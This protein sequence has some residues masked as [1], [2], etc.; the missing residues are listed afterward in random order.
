MYAHLSLAYDCILVH[1]ITPILNHVLLYHGSSLSLYTHTR[2]VPHFCRYVQMDNLGSA[3]AN[4]E[5]W[6]LVNYLEDGGFPALL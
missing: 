6:T 5:A 3:S 1:M 2:L 4:V